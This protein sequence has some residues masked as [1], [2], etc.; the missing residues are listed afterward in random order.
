MHLK[1]DKKAEIFL[2]IVYETIVRGGNVVIPT[3]AVRQNTRNS[4]R[5]KQNKRKYS[6]PNIHKQIQSTNGNTSICRQSTCNISNRNI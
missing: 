4:I 1:N 6:R 2:N 5:A 3:F